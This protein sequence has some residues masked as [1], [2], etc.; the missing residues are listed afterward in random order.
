MLA[1]PKT[2]PTAVGMRE[3]KPPT[4]IPLSMTKTTSTARLVERGQSMTKVRPNSV[5]EENKTFKEPSRSLSHPDAIRP[6]ADAK[7]NP[8]ARPAPTLGDRPI[9]LANSGRQYGGTK[10]GNDPHS[11]AMNITENLSD[12]KNDLREHVS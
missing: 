5:S 9:D 3:K 6:T 2:W 12:L 10:R 8:A 1:D 7:L 11:P 4:K